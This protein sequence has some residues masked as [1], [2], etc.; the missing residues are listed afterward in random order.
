MSGCHVIVIYLTKM[1]PEARRLL[2]KGIGLLSLFST[3]KGRFTVFAAVLV[4]IAVGTTVYTHKNVKQSSDAVAGNLAIRYAS[5]NYSQQIH[6]GLFDSYK[7]LSA[8]LLDPTRT[9]LQAQIHT[10]LQ[11][12]IEAS[13]ALSST[14]SPAFVAN[15][16]IDFNELTRL[17]MAL[18]ADVSKVLNTRLKSREQYPALGQGNQILRP[19][20]IQFVN[21][22]S[23]AM[24]EMSSEQESYDQEVFQ[25]LVKARFLWSQ[26]V[27]NFRLYL[28]N[29]FGS[30]DEEALKQQEVGIGQLYQALQLQLAVLDKF[31]QEDKLGF[32]AANALADMIV[33][34]RG[35]YQ[36]FKAVKNINRS[37]EWRADVVLIRTNIEPKLEAITQILSELNA[38]FE[39]ESLDGIGLL[40]TA[41]ETQ[42]RFMLYAS[43]CIVAF[44]ILT[45]LFF[46]KMVLRPVRDVAKAMKAVAFGERGVTI[47]ATGAKETQYLVDAF[48]E[49]RSQVRSRQ[50][51]LEHQALHDSLTGLAN[52]ILL[53]DRLDQ[54]VYNARLAKTECALLIIDIDRFKEINESLGHHAGDALLVEVG[55]RLESILRKIDTVA[56]LGGDEFAVLLPQSNLPYARRVIDKIEQAL[57][58]I[59]S[60]NGSPIYV[61]GTIG[62]AIYPEHGSSPGILLRHADTALHSAKTTQSNFSFYDENL[63]DDN[64]D[65]LTLSGDLRDAI[66][67]DSLHLVYQPQFDF[68][69]SFVVGVEALVR[70]DHPRLGA[71]VPDEI[72]SL[73]EQTGQINAL[74]Y[75]V[76]DTAVR[77]CAEWRKSGLDIGMSINLSVLNLQ[78]GELIE[79]IKNC[80]SLYDLGQ[81]CLTVEITESAMMINP[82]SA[83]KILK[84]LEAMGLKLVIDDFG[85]GFSSLSYLKQLPVEKLKLDKSFVISLDKDSNDEVIVRSTIELA[86]NLGL[87]VVA[88]GVENKA[89]WEI[90]R[91]LKCDLGQGFYMSK[92]KS[93]KEITKW[94]NSQV[95]VESIAI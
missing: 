9:E 74:T 27:S 6:D 31:E 18:N 67:N 14:V 10:S 88:E 55:L 76:L 73:A 66:N 85:T 28:A 62:V 93:A 86:H 64:A 72:V 34:S 94:L 29:R 21:A 46:E 69:S 4:L 24:Y 87:Q 68:N 50:F 20:R 56:R 35:W 5:Q 41:A 1:Q 8:F 43:L 54:A 30:F 77:Q 82:A 7:K 39:A 3:L 23:V 75:W 38:H 91:N 47:P 83:M 37:G 80:L 53:R 90:L 70:W 63:Y 42:S 81:N 25:A 78:D 19:N 15:T 57:G 84:K 71:I 52:R 12:T 26:M 65:R 13:Q 2:N 36:G 59:H 89:S 40:V 58:S 16:S 33:S 32:E 45:I 49:M 61:S 79:Q 44:F 92:P 22:M 95:V 17:L 11:N 51:E 60:I 48:N